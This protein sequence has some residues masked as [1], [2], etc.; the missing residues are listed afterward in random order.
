ML[1]FLTN[2]NNKVNTKIIYLKL[3]FIKIKYEG[4]IL[5]LLIDIY[6]YIFFGEIN[7]I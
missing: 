1:L 3:N 6:K 2:I 5:S 4:L 7:K